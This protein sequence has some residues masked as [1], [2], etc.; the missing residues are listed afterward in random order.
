MPVGTLLRKMGK[1]FVSFVVSGIDYACYVVEEFRN[2]AGKRNE[3][4]DELTRIEPMPAEIIHSHNTSKGKFNLRVPTGENELV[5]E[6]SN[7]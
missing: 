2:T 3:W 4:G 1:S 6:K 5:K 7:D